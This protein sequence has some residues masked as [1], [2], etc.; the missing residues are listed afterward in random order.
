LKFNYTNPLFLALIVF[1]K[2]MGINQRSV[3]QKSYSHQK[4][5]ELVG[6]GIIEHSQA[7]VVKLKC[8]DMI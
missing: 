2:K 7:K 8:E 3:N 6:I 4:I 5:M 1:L